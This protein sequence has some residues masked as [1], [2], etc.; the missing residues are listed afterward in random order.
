MIRSTLRS[1]VLTFAAAAVPMALAGS[2]GPELPE[3]MKVDEAAKKVTI[4]IVAGTD[5]T[6]N[7][8]NYNTV[9]KGAKSIVVPVG[10]EVEIDFRN[11]DP[12]GVV[13][14][15]GVGQMSEVTSPLFTDPTPAFPGAISDNAADPVNAT[16]AGASETITFV[17]DTAGEYALICYVP[18]H[19]L[20]GMW[21]GFRVA[22]DGS[23]GVE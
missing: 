11:S 7:G 23:V 10:F 12:T 6:N 15:I 13:H 9:F 2:Q 16:A 8:W 20:T 21:M 1:L 22:A 5:M 19:T 17:A 4:T 14:S 3:W 18:G